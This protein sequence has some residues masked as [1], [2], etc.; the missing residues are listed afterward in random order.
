MDGEKNTYFQIDFSNNTAASIYFYSALVT[1]HFQRENYNVTNWIS[2]IGM[3]L[4][5]RNG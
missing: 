5:G 4:A 3:N 1:N 2:G